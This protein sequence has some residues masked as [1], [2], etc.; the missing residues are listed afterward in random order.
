MRNRLRSAALLLAFT[1]VGAGL[2]SCDQGGPS[3]PMTADE[4]RRQII[5]SASGLQEAAATFDQTPLARLSGAMMGSGADGKKVSPWGEALISGLG[6][7]LDT[8]GGSFNYDA[9]T[10]AY[11]W[12]RTRRPGAKS[13]RPTAS[14]FGFRSPQTHRATTQP[15]R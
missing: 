6:A 3:P 13:A 8:T 11:V 1:L 2:L 10:G 4:A 12:T 14:S 15:L 9:S 5:E 7:V